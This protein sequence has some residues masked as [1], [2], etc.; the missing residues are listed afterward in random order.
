MIYGNHGKL[1][2][3]NLEEKKFTVEEIGAE[4]FQRCIGGKGLGTHLLLE[5]VDPKVDPL[6]PENK[7]IFTTG[8][9]C[10]TQIAASSRYGVFSKSPLTGIYAESY[11]GGHVA[12]QMKRSGFD[13]FILEGSSSTPVYLHINNGGVTFH[14]ADNLWGLDS[15]QAEDRMKEEVGI[16]A[17]QALVIGPA[18]EN[19]VK[20][21]CIKNNYWR[22]AGRGGMG[23]VL[24]SK[25]IKGLVFSGDV[26]A[27]Q[28]DPELLKQY[29]SDLKEKGRDN[30]GVKAYYTYGTPMMVAMLNEVN[31]FPTRYWHQGKMENWQQISAE[32][33]QDT[34]EVRSKACRGCFMACGKLTTVLR[35]R[36][37]G[38]Q[39]E[40]PE[41][42]TI[43][44][45]GG[46]CCIDSLEEIVY[47]NDL[48]DRLG[49]DTISAGNLAAFAMEAGVKGKLEDAPLYGDVDAVA[50]LFNDIASR[51]GLGE[52]LSQGIVA[53]SARL[54][55]ED[56]AI[57]VKGMEPPGYD[58]RYLKG[59]GL[60]YAISDR[61]ACHLR[62][63][64]YKPELSGMIPP[65]QVEGK[66]EL[67]IDFEDRMT[68]F[69]CLIYCRFYRDMVTWDDLAVV[70]EATTG[71]KRNKE[72]LKS[73][74]N[75]IV[76]RARRFNL[77]AGVTRA[78]DTLPA[79]FFDEPL[80]KAGQ[81][82]ITRQELDFMVGE[83]YRLRG[84]DEQ[85]VPPAE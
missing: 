60:G 71:Q 57:H 27:P 25:K 38:L 52:L 66:A 47:L 30:P 28:A 32:T 5:E 20:F 31:S 51:R 68:L 34:M 69:D 67:F 80:D 13:A 9:A 1:L 17:A 23:A 10:D 46:L 45:L 21:A 61:G 19:L 16:K 33:M 22:S 24:G 2:R 42:E 72:E 79:R 84:W 7:I 8:P 77:E 3:I 49:L 82:V 81:Q 14:E 36:H 29:I 15:Y 70:V 59:M 58:P 37:R 55:L 40:G 26:R 64:F 18:G 85:G 48:C 54:G 41:F 74:A 73:I 83:Y 11:S 44:A 12:P 4:V 78:D 76:S 56:L 43:Y 39:I 63:T 62:A 35:G 53:A 75:D 50:R 6:A 65:E